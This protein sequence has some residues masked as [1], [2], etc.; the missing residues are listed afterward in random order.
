METVLQLV[1]GQVWATALILETDP[2]LEAGRGQAIV[3]LLGAGQA[4]DSYKISSTYQITTGQITTGQVETG[5]A[6]VL[7]IHR[8]PVLEIVRALVLRNQTAR[9]LVTVLVPETFLPTGL[10]AAPEK[11]ISP[12]INATS[13]ERI[14][15]PMSG[16]T[17]MVGMEMHS[18]GHGGL[19]VPV[20]TGIIGI[21]SIIGIATRLIIFGGQLLRSL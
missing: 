13:I 12:S 1:T 17:G 4:K 3:L 14:F 10:D 8:V 15:L 11:A 18:T 6:L 9:V 21:T 2:A 5:R 19:G 7:Q 16:G 20:G